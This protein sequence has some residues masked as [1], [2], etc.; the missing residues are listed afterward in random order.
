MTFTRPRSNLFYVL[1]LATIAVM[2]LLPAVWGHKR[3]PAGNA[4]VLSPTSSKAVRDIHIFTV[5][6]KTKQNGKEMEVYR[7]DPETVILYKEETA[8]LHF[9]GFQGKEHR[10]SIPGLGVYTTI[11][12]GET[13]TVTVKPHKTGTFELVCHTHETVESHGPMIGYVTVLEK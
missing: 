7:W 11:H 1:A 3:I 9:H 5:E 4:A 12:K 2:V 13:A 10:F 8:R 6:F